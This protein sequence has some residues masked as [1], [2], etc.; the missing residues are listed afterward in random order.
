MIPK[1]P[2]N[3][4]IYMKAPPLVGVPPDHV[5][6]LRRTLYGLKQASHHWHSEFDKTMISL[7]FKPSTDVTLASTFKF[8]LANWLLQLLSS[9]TIV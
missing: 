5:L 1:L 3:E 2:E 4:V 6:R 9:W 7:G 8:V